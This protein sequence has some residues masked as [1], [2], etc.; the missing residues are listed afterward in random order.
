MEPAERD[1]FSSA[2]DRW[3]GL[4]RHHLEECARRANPGVVV[5]ACGEKKSEILVRVLESGLA[6]ILL[7][8]DSLAEAVLE[9]LSGKRGNAG[10]P[11]VVD[12]Q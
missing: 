5:A 9:K 1:K 6:S 2:S 3:L 4:T 10:I 12:A 8:D 7:I 11:D